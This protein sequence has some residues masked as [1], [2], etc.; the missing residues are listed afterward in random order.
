MWST[1]QEKPVNSLRCHLMSSDE[2][3]NFDFSRSDEPRKIDLND[4][5]ILS[6]ER[7]KNS[8]TSGGIG[9]HLRNNKMFF[10]FFFCCCCLLSFICWFSKASPS[11]RM[12]F[13]SLSLYCQ[14]THA[15]FPFER[16]QKMESNIDFESDSAQHSNTCIPIHFHNFIILFTLQFVP[17]NSKA[18]CFFFFLPLAPDKSKAVHFAKAEMA[19][20]CVDVYIV[21]VVVVALPFFGCLSFW[22]IYKRDSYRWFSSDKSNSRKTKKC[23]ECKRKWQ[24]H[25][26]CCCPFV[27]NRHTPT[28]NREKLSA[29][30]LFVLRFAGAFW[31]IVSISHCNRAYSIAQ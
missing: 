10:L 4:L 17:L 30:Y 12:H 25:I 2:S 15:K 31:L 24:K 8:M 22:K 16:E 11:P 5:S 14:S 7:Q 29:L 28:Y 1:R 3:V 18:F 21:C 26:C 6:C 13:L 23:E 9:H 20:I 19:K 27:H